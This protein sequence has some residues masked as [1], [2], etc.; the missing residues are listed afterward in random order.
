MAALAAGRAGNRNR[1]VIGERR[2]GKGAH[3]DLVKVAEQVGWVLIH[4]VGSG[5]LEFA[6]PIA[7]SKQPDAQRTSPTRSEHVP[8]AVADDDRIL[9]IDAKPFS[10]RQEEI[11]V[12]LG[13]A[14]IVACHQGDRVR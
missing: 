4:P 9:G 1:L 14:N 5:Q 10:S 13:M 7:A 8:D 6:L 2:R 11:R 12:G 3:A